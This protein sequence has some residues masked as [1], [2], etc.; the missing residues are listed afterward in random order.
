MESQ[1]QDRGRFKGT[2]RKHGLHALAERPEPETSTPGDVRMTPRSVRG[3][4]ERLE[5]AL[6]KRPEERMGLLDSATQACHRQSGGKPT[7]KTARG[8]N[9][10]GRPSAAPRPRNHGATNDS[11]GKGKGKNG[12][13]APKLPHQPSH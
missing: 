3:E 11:K 7:S 2:F 8:N 13:Q 1:H 5:Q 9:P 12:R 10:A 4:E 6:G